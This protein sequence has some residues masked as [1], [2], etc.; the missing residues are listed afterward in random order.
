MIKRVRRLRFQTEP[1]QLRNNAF[2]GVMNDGDEKNVITY[3]DV[4]AAVYF[5][6]VHPTEKVTQTRVVPLTAC[7]WVELL[8]EPETKPP[9]K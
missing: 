8:N 1:A 7:A 2:G 3:D 6:R 9:A 5:T 4:A